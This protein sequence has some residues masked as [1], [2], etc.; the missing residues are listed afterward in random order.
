MV[1]IRRRSRAWQRPAGVGVATL[2]A[3]L[4]RLPW[5]STP[6]SECPPRAMRSPR[7]DIKTDPPCRP[8]WTC[9]V[10]WSPPPMVMAGHVSSGWLFASTA[11]TTRTVTAGLHSHR[12]KAITPLRTEPTPR[13]VA[14]GRWPINPGIPM[15]SNLARDDLLARFDVRKGVSCQYQ[16]ASFK[17][18]MRLKCLVLWVTSVA[19]MVI[20]SPAI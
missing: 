10:S 1:G 4:N 2:I 16:S 20:A 5:A 15:F 3:W 11:P 8:E 17:P 13:P 9:Q 12:A 14:A 7:E 18:A 6:A 19:P